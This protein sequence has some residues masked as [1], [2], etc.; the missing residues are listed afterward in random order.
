MGLHTGEAQERDGNY[1][2][3]ALNRAARLMA[4]GAGGQILMSATTAGIVDVGC[5]SE[6]M[7]ELRGLADRMEVFSVLGDGLPTAFAPLRTA[8]PLGNLPPHALDLVGRE[9]LVTEL[10]ADLATS[11]LLTLVGPGGIGKTSVAVELAR[12]VEWDFPGGVWLVEVAP[13]R[14]PDAVVAALGSAVGARADRGA[15]LLEAVLGLLRPQRALVVVDNCE[16]LI[17]ATAAVVQ[18][19]IAGSSATVVATSRAPLHLRGEVVRQVP[20]LAFGGDRS[21]AERL[22]VARARQVRDDFDFGDA[23][24]TPIAAICELVDGMPLAVELAAARCRSLS[25]ADVLARLE[26]DAGSVLRDDRRDRQANHE[27][28][29]ATIEWSYNLLSRPEQELFGACRYSQ[30]ASISPQWKPWARAECPERS[31]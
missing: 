28:L 2:G 26:R 7:C 4:L 25:P 5:R 14:D 9:L 21:D 29:D 24:A 27:T 12:R 19:I 8:A 31:K 10:T 16:H 6:G 15:T 22:F 17:A 3:T 18:A 11:R 23:V 30:E 13:L 1:F 20:P